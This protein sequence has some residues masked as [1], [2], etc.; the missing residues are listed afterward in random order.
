MCVAIR[1]FRFILLRVIHDGGLIHGV[2]V[3]QAP[4]KV[5]EWAR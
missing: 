5:I 2:M 4:T 1:S 3:A